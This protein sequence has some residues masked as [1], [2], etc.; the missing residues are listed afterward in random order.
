MGPF[1]HLLSINQHLPVLSLISLGPHRRRLA[2]LIR[3]AP[4][5]R[6]QNSVMVVTSYEWGPYSIAFVSEL[7]LSED[8]TSN[9]RKK[10]RSHL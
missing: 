1:C 9:E 6:I 10:E 8:G 4:Y 5:E 2:T 3:S 7:G